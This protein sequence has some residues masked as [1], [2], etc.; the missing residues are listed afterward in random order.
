ML[1][2]RILTDVS[3]RLRAEQWFCR[4]ALE[5]AGL[6][7]GIPTPPPLLF[8]GERQVGPIIMPVR[9]RGIAWPTPDGSVNVYVVHSAQGPEMLCET[10]F[11]EARHVKTF[12]E[13]NERGTVTP[14]AVNEAQAVFFAWSES[15]T[16]D[17]ETIMR[18]LCSE[19][20]LLSL[21]FN[22]PKS[23]TTFAALLKPYD[24]EAAIAFEKRAD[25]L[26]NTCEDAQTPRDE[27]LVRLLNRQEFSRETKLT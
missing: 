15:P 10:I 1:R 23:A 21:E 2:Y 3:D 22:Q 17:Y 24:L 26:A 18:K 12:M 5:V 13:D 25:V 4:L 6:K 20:A 27:R 8:I 14:R 16:G 19:G 7:L 11:H 9:V